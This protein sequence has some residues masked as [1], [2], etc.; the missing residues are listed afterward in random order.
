VSSGSV[1]WLHCQKISGLGS[2]VI[3]LY[4]GECTPGVD[5]YAL[6]LVRITNDRATFTSQHNF[7]NISNL[8]TFFF[9]PPFKENQGDAEV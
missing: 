5:Q 7:F 8:F 6:V 3:Q 2:V 9:V 1:S 4:A